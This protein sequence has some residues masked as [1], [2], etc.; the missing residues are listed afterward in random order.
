M[1]VSNPVGGVEVRLLCLL[2]ARRWWPLRR[3]DHLL[4]GVLPAVC[5]IKFNLETSKMRGP[6]PDLGCSTTEK[7]K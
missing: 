3:A 6:R 2:S 5:V 4:R 1:A 7:E